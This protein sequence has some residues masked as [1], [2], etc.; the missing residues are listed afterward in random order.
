[1]TK[2]EVKAIITATAEKH[3]F[4]AEEN[5]FMRWPNITEQGTHYL[6][7]TITESFAED[8]DWAQREVTIKLDFRAS[9]AS[10]GGNPTPDD[11]IDVSEIIRSGAEL[12]KELES[13]G[14]ACTERY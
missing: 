12:V 6:N 13:M 5:T 4:I 14:L 8:T 11:L 3:G 7:F 2:N 10:M 9:L 1:M